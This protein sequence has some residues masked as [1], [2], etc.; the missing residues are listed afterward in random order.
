MVDVATQAD[1]AQPATG[2]NLPADSA[3]FGNLL[4]ASPDGV[5]IC[6]VRGNDSPVVYV[7]RAFEQL[8]GYRASE[9]IGRNMRFLHG[10]D[11]DQEGLS[12]IRL[13]LREG[14]AAQTILRNYRKD[15]TLFWNELRLVPIRN[16]AGQVAHFA[17]FHRE[18]GERLKPDARA[19]Q[20]SEPRDPALNTQTMLAYLRDDKLTGLLRRGYFDELLKRDLGIAQRESRTL[21][22]FLFDPDFFE[23][24]RELFGRPGADQSLR[25]IGRTI[26]ACFR[27]A[28]DL[29]ARFDDTR[30]AALCTGMEADQA[31]K[32]ADTV[33]ARIRDLAIHHPRSAV[34]RF[35][36]MSSGVITL[37]PSRDIDNEKL[38]AAAQDALQ[39]A[40]DEGRNRVVSV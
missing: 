2:S 14:V 6:D 11:R 24:Y 17:S 25:R 29:C 8:S 30:V 26:G 7:N 27:R 38:I 37:T 31:A 35:M 13:A 21:S 16:A 10:E 5:V 15:G 1:A 32:Y 22:L 36:T 23:P 40:R 39:K 4:D 3:L 18:A 33:L 20:R 19:E 28:S 12:R 9:L 34:S